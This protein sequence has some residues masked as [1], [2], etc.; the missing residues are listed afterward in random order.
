MENRISSM[1]SLLIAQEEAVRSRDNEKRQ[2]SS[3]V[4][5]LEFQL[6]SKDSQIKQLTV[7]FFRLK[8]IGSVNFCVSLI[9]KEKHDELRSEYEKI[10]IER[11]KLREELS[12][13][14]SDKQAYEIDLSEK[15]SETEKYKNLL[16]DFD[17]ERQVTF[18]QTR[19]LLI[20][21][22]LDHI[23]DFI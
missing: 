11:R 10:Q 19:F 9:F 3:R 7:R 6:K 13:I 8:S 4:N 16:K 1:Q 15:S 17:L 21:V 2:I 18:E 14:E 20:F 12:S 22:L 23:F 5:Q